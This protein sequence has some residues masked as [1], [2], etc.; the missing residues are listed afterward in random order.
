[1]SNKLIQKDLFAYEV[2][3]YILSL[4]NISSTLVLSYSIY[5][6]WLW[7]QVDCILPGRHN[8]IGKSVEPIVELKIMDGSENCN[9]HGSL[10]TIQCYHQLHCPSTYIL[11]QTCTIH[12]QRV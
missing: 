12:S 8:S 3:K 2:G 5:G 6:L 1:M 11:G 7:V 10:L 9:H 4:L